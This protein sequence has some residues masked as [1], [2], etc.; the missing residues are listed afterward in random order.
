M[1]DDDVLAQV[2]RAAGAED[3]YELRTFHVE[4]GQRTVQVTVMDAGPSAGA[5]RYMVE[6]RE[7]AGPAPDGPYSMGN[8]AGSI[9]EALNIAHWQEFGP[10]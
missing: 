3:G 8:P 9:D 4:R 10:A 2:L 6:L 7:A 1:A 5:Q